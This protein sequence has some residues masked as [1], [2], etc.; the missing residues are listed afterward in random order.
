[1][2]TVRVD[3]RIDLQYDVSFVSPYARDTPAE[4]KMTTWEAVE[5]YLRPRVLPA[6]AT[7][8]GWVTGLNGS[9]FG[10]VAGTTPESVPA[11]GR[12]DYGPERP[13]LPLLHRLPVTCARYREEALGNGS[14]ALPS[15]EDTMRA[16]HGPAGWCKNAALDAV[17]EKLRVQLEFPPLLSQPPEDFRGGQ[18][19]DAWWFW[20]D[21]LLPSVRPHFPAE[22]ITAVER[23]LTKGVSVFEFMKEFHGEFAARKW[24]DATPPAFQRQN[25]PVDS[26]EHREFVDAEVAKLLRVGAVEAVHKKPHLCLPIG[27]VMGHKLRMI[28][29]ARFL[30]CWTPSP[31]MSYESLRAFQRGINQDDYVAQL[32]HKSGYHHVRMAEDSWQ[33]LGF[34]WKGRYY[35]FRVLP[36]GWAPACY[37]YNTL[38]DIVATYL[39][40]CGVHLIFYLDDFGFAFSGRLSERERHWELWRV[41]AIMYFAGYCVARDKSMLVSQRTMTLLGFGIDTHRM[42]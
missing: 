9:Q 29:D 33:Y 2:G 32:D 40:M 39:R 24:A 25:H 8:A 12:T 23:W 22:T 21:V 34:R 11:P 36:F 16:A 18:L 6:L 27:V 41:W 30:N 13:S 31:D 35:V 15:S 4:A 10:T 5:Q 20:R 14:C 37:V 28:F 19:Q 7:R 17:R 3:L 42:R 1:M 38:S 26:V